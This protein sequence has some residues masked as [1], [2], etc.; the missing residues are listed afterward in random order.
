MVAMWLNR[1][2]LAAFVVALGV[3]FALGGPVSAQ[4]PQG[5]APQG[6]SGQETEEPF[7]QVKLTEAQIKGF[8]GA[9]KEMADLAQKEGGQQPSESADPKVQA[10]LETIA[11]KHGFATFVDFDDVAFNISMVI[12]GLDEQGAFTDPVA[13]IKK[14]IEDIKADKTIA[15]KDK[16]QMLEELDEALKHTPNLQYPENVEIVKKHRAEIEKVLQ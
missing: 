7:K 13:S 15:D 6:Q 2:G 11:K 9:Q 1:N 14:E 4:A 10:Q 16:K 5:Q 12:G 3:G 8:L